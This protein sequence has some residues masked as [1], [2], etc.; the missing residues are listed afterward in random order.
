MRL[1]AL[2]NGQCLGQLL[3]SY[4]QGTSPLSCKTGIG[5]RVTPMQLRRKQQSATPPGLPQAHGP[6]WDPPEGAEGAVGS[7]HQA[8]LHH[9]SA[10]VLGKWGR[11][12][13]TG[14][15]QCDDH[16]QEGLEGR[17]ELQACQPDLGKGKAME[18][19]I[20]NA[21]TQHV[22]DN[23]GIRRSQHAFMKSAPVWP[24]SSP[25]VTR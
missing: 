6:R 14:D 4:P 11:S 18:Q 22:R 8:T 24:T 1:L 12:Q 16:L 23:R 13:M 7:A 9:T 15:C 5:S 17:P 25:S 19:I 2:C 3:V 21:I 10:V 20:L